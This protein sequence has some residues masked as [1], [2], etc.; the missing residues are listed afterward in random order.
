MKDIP[1]VIICGPTGIGKT[2]LGIEIARNINGEIISADSRQIYKDFDIGTAKPT[3]EE[4]NLI[5]HYLIDFVEPTYNFTVSE[6][7]NLAKETIIHIVNKNK[8]PIIVGGTGLYIKAVTEDFDIPKVKPDYEIRNKLKEISKTEEGKSYLY[9]KAVE[10]DP[11]A[12]EK[13][14]K[15]DLIR[16]IRL[17]EVFETTGNKIS[18]MRKK[19]VNNSYK[20]AY[21]SLD[22]ER[23]ELYKRICIRVNKMIEEGL[24]DEVKFI[25]N[26]YGEDLPLLKTINYKE[27]RE[28]LLGNINLENTIELMKK[29]T[30]NFAKRQLTWFRNTPNINIFSL[31]EN[32]LNDIINFIRKKVNI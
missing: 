31:K 9:K 1:L 25:I 11:K 24:I 19:N 20:L 7:L 29:N 3:K 27:I 15:N 10:I 30:R 6:Y 14:H 13:I 8:I 26:K 4:R 5:K 28:Y 21:L 17:I 16:I 23:N 12:M 32:S 22:I 18:E 2:S